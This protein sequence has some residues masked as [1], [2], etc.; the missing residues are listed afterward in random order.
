MAERRLFSLG[1]NSQQIL[2]TRNGYCK[3]DERQQGRQDHKRRRINRG[4]K[5]GK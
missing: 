1:Q 2:H 4:R 5:K 3:A